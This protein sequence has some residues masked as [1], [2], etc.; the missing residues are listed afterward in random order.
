MNDV[1]VAF[2]RLDVLSKYSERHLAV[3]ILP[4]DVISSPAVVY[5]IYC[6]SVFLKKFQNFCQV[7][8]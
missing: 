1:S 4:G 7:L 5:T 3:V 6:L 8:C 2:F